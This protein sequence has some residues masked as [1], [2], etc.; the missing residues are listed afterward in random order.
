M[1]A[2]WKAFCAGSLVLIVL[3]AEVHAQAPAANGASTAGAAGAAGAPAAA[4]APSAGGITGLIQMLAAHNAACKAKLCSCPIGQLFTNML[5]PINAITGGLLCTSCCDDL[6]QKQDQAKPST[7]AQGACAKIMAEEAEMNARRA[8]VRCLARVDC[9]W[10]PEAEE[11][12]INA[13]RTDR[14]ECVRLEAAL[15]LGTGCCC[16]KKTIEA[17]TIVV[18]GSDKDANPYENSER[19]KAA[20]AGSLQHCLACYEERP[21]RPEVPKPKPEQPAQEKPTA[22]QNNAIQLTTYYVQADQRS[23]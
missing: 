12:L 4:P 18:T 3:A 21:Q 17:L 11:S 19:V 7:S 10:W 20:A 8:A 23:S 9:H 2:D 16:T 22:M 13:L 6:K 5:K 14:N 15:V 1:Y